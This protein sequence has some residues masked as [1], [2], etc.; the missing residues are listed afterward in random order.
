MLGDDRESLF[1]YPK[2]NCGL[3][4]GRRESIRLQLR[5][6]GHKAGN[7]PPRSPLLPSALIHPVIMPARGNGIFRNSPDGFGR[8]RTEGFISPNVIYHNTM[9][10]S[11]MGPYLLK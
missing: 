2:G 8:N 3:T 10:F 7:I 9:N 1:I 11:C 4:V 5:H 6:L